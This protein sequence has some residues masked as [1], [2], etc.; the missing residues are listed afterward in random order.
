MRSY[1]IFGFKS[2]NITYIL[3]LGI[4]IS[5]MIHMVDYLHSISSFI[6]RVEVTDF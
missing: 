5:I 6:I 3:N 2:Y 4:D 1:Y